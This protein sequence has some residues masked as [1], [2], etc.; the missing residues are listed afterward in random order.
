MRK[1]SDVSRFPSSA[2]LFR[3]CMKVLDLRNPG[4]KVH[5]QELG[6]ILQYN[7]SDT[8]HW[9][10]GKKA[11]RSVYALEALAHHLETDVD[12]LQD[13]VEGA[14][15]FDEA[16]TDFV[17]NE[18]EKKFRAE[19]SSE[20]L[21]LRR[22]RQ[23]TLDRVAEEILQKAGVVSVPVYVPEILQV[24]PFIHL[25]HGE[26]SDKIAWSSRL[27]P[28]QYVR[29]IA[30]VIL[31]SERE[32]FSIPPKIESL[33]AVEIADFTSALFVPKAA[34]KSEIQRVSARANLVKTLADVFWVPKNVIRAR[35]GALI[36]EAA[37]PEVLSADPISISLMGSVPKLDPNDFGEDDLPTPNAAVPDTVSSD[38]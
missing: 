20:L 21:E 19:A 36:L 32:Q 16:W 12:L 25:S 37:S 4:H 18:E 11:L 7:P 28:G 24:L 9:K 35:M 22:E 1:T 29:E 33:S 31:F 30:R 23:L 3:F 14:I 26:V 38:A 8:S 2:L 10:R 27:K 15:D 17:D 34:L 6:N 5:D 13:L